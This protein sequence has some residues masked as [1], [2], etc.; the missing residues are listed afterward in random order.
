MVDARGERP[1]ASVPAAYLEGD[2]SLPGRREEPA[3]GEDAADLL[4]AAE[5][6]DPCFGEDHRIHRPC[7]N[8][9]DPRVDVSSNLL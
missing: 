4:R 2:R 3:E 7:A 5:P 8:Q 9:R 6:V 1:G